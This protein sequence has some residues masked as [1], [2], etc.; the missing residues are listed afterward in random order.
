VCW[1]LDEAEARRTVHRLWAHTAI[2]GEAGQLLPSPAHF[3]QLA[4]VV[5]E[6]M[7]VESVGAVGNRVED[8]VE[9]VRPYVE[10]GYDEVYLSQI[11]EEQDGWFD[12]FE[13][14]LRP[15]L[16]ELSKA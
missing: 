13:R 10:A 5:T 11:G 4:S 12:F 7:A 1:S 9:A 14:E 15:A 8:F 6:E 16:A 3:E 2:P